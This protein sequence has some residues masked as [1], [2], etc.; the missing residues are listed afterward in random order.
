MAKYRVEALLGAW[1]SSGGPYS[2]TPGTV[3]THERAAQDLQDEINGIAMDGYKL[4]AVISSGS[5]V[6]PLAVYEDLG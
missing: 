3:R 1:T 4:V 5:L 2:G 6:H